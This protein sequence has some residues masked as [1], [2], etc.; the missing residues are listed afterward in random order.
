MEFFGIIAFILVLSYSSYPSKL[1]KLERKIKKISRNMKEESSM[2]KLIKDLKGDKCLISSDEAIFITGKTDMECQ[3]IDVD[4]EWIKITFVDKK[5]I[6][7]TQII[8]IDTIDKIE[9]ITY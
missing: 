2:S 8:R 4:D 9:L 3:I 5:D 7:K 1:N 6:K